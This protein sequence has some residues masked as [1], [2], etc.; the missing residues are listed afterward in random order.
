VGVIK[1]DTFAAVALSSYGGFW[2]SFYLL[3]RTFLKQIPAASQGDALAL[4]LFCWA[5]FTFYMW[6]ASFRV[7][8][9]V[10][11]VFLTLWPTYFFLGLA[12]RPRSSTSV[13]ASAWPP[14]SPPGT[15]RRPSC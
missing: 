1:N 12:R 2:I 15:S 14:H 11:T 13:V 4:Y 9:G 7:S 3:Q 10:Q 6:L 8:L 5:A